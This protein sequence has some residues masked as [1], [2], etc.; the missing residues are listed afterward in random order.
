VSDDGTIFAVGAKGGSYIHAVDPM[1]NVKRSFAEAPV[2]SPA[3]MARFAGE[4]AT[5]VWDHQ[6][7]RLFYLPLNPFDIRV[8]SRSG[9]L[10]E[11]KRAVDP[12]FHGM[13]YDAARDAARPGDEV[14][15]AAFLPSGEL[16][17]QTLKAV[18][19]PS[20]RFDRTS[21]LVVLSH[22]LRVVLDT[23]PLPGG[24]G[25]L[26]GISADGTLFFLRA[27]DGDGVFVKGAQLRQASP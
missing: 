27:N 21:Q 20:G 1:G 16:V 15:F 19:L 11:E 26:Q 14:R 9:D 7:Q 5:L 18:T 22:D 13:R 6:E 8:Y 10:V 23:V 2:Q 12:L 17:V 24:F 3:T 4:R 25:S